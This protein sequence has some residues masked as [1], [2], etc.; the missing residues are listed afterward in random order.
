MAVV[1]AFARK[2]SGLTREAS[3]LD[4]TYFGILN[5]AVPVS[6]WFVLAAFAWLPG[7][8]LALASILTLI[9][10]VFG[11][12]FIWGILGG[13]M[14][15]SGGSYVYNSRIIH[16]TIGMAVSF[17]NAALVMLM[18]I[19]V[20][21]PWVG[22]IG[23]P[24]MAGTL[25]IAP[26]AVEPFTYGWGLYGI[27]TVVN[28]TAVLTIIAGM[29]L[30]FRIQKAFVTWSL[31]GAAIA[32]II[33]STTSH[34]EFVSI[35]NSYAVQTGSLEFDAAVSAAAA[36]MGGIPATWNWT[37]TIAMM[38]PISWIAIYGYIITFIGGEVKSPR[39]NIF[40]AQILNA[41]ICVVFL[42]WVGLA[43]QRML[44]W[45]G[46]HAIAWIG[47]EGVEGF[48][49]PFY[50]TYLNI[51]AM[52]VGFN[53]VL[54]FIMAGSFI[55]AVWL[56][57]AFSY[58]AWSR[59]AFAWGMDRLGPRWFTDLSPRFG[60]PVK[61]LLAM[62]IASQLAITYYCIDP[63]ILLA[64]GVETLQLLSV[65]GVTAVA[66]LIFPFVGK[67]R[68]IWDASPF[69]G[70]R[71]GPVPVATIA[72][73]LALILVITLVYAF[74]MTEGYVLSLA[75]WAGAWTI[76]Y[77]LAWGLGIGWYFI[78]KRKRAKEGIDVTLAFKELP[79]E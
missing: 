68:H 18:W 43:Y 21:A 66:C 71:I 32:G 4:T 45:E 50:L 31:V 41:V 49:F 55:V 8:N 35:W 61:L 51:A 30:F 39:A 78:W 16:P 63:E 47:E 64:M 29:R 26:E 76:V 3:L 67:V 25:G 65:F 5:N 52:I 54:G 73:C 2:A 34:A 62:F 19:W 6:L 38:L 11:F 70:W 37:A 56:W 13:S 40:R 42:L 9:L 58:I 27:T 10:V 72:G 17:C 12:A 28:V 77:L 48:T 24:I 53:K 22:E 14:P 79:P 57:V 20:L 75:G 44:G 74:Y 7:A 15:R 23:L 46:I 69:R 60:Q 59:A 33:I 36:E 1:E